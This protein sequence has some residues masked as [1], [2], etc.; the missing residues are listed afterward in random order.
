[1]IIFTYISG[2]LT[3]LCIILIIATVFSYK[4]YTL[5]L[6]TTKHHLET[7]TDRYNEMISAVDE[8]QLGLVNIEDQMREDGYKNTIEIQQK[9][10]DLEKPLIQLSIVVGNMKKTQD[11]Q[12]EQLFNDVGMLR[13]KVNSSSKDSNE[14]DRY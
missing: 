8:T 9:V 10:S 1:M 5:L 4:K 6:K 12:I 3:A 11:K 14:I 2:L 7:S 13:A